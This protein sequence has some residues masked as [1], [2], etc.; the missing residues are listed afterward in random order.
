METTTPDGLHLK[1]VPLW[2][3]VTAKLE[4]IGARATEFVTH[5]DYG[6]FRA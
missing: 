1:L 6:V 4:P 2:D 5:L 3:G